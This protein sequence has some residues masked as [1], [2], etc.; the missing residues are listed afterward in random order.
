[1]SAPRSS[2]LSVKK[3]FTERNKIQFIRD[4]FENWMCQQRWMILA[5]TTDC[6]FVTSD[7]PVTNWADRAEGVEVGVGFADP[8]FRVFF[9]ITPRLGVAVLQTV[10][11]LSAILNDVEESS[12]S[13]E[14]DLSIESSEL[15]LLDV[16][17]HN[18]V[19][20]SN[21]E[22]YAYT[23]TNDD[24][25]REF[26]KEQ[27]IHRSAPVRRFDLRPIGSPVSDKD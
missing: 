1:M 4:S 24:R 17:R 16:L 12:F 18:Q 6:P 10:E 25:M 26:L 13:R 8:G 21:A 20:I 9:P 5:N 19:T 14:Y 3:R 22:R 27:F 2:N 11:A 7:N 15:R 23:N